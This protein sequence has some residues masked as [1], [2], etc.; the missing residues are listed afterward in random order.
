MSADRPGEADAESDGSRRA[1]DFPRE[2]TAR[3]RD[4]LLAMIENG[5]PDPS[6]DSP[7]T[8]RRRAGWLR[9]VDSTLVYGTCGCGNC[10]SIDLGDVTGP[11]P[12]TG[13]RDVLVAEHGSAAV[14]LFIDD[15]RPSYL[16]LAT[17]DDVRYEEFPDTTQLRF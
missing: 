10:P 6:D 1:T 15:D 12:G 8:P 4:V 3:E 17:A 9:R 16:E 13:D 7:I 2:L 14:L 11:N 5:Q